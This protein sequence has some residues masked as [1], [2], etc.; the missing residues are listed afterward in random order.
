MTLAKAK[1]QAKAKVKH[2]Y[3]TAV[4]YNRHLQSSKYF[5]NTGHTDHTE[6]NRRGSLGVWEASQLIL[7]LLNCKHTDVEIKQPKLGLQHMPPGACIIKLIMAVIYSFRNKLE[8]L[9]LESL[10]SLVLC[11]VTNTLAF[12]ETINYGCD[13]FY[14]TGPR[15]HCSLK[16]IITIINSIAW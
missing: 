10:S 16:L 2:I 13:M 4:I 3:S 11:L 6:A 1:A 5:Y 14:D 7:D 15:R 9:S 12:S 8:C